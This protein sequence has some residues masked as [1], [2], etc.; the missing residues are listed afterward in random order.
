MVGH[1]LLRAEKT[2]RR[3]W[4]CVFWGG[5]G[6]PPRLPRHQ[7]ESRRAVGPGSVGGVFLV[8]VRMFFP[9]T[10]SKEIGSIF[11]TICSKWPLAGIIAPPFVSPVL[12]SMSP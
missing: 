8:S 12:F 4:L 1:H 9:K 7:Q 6:V 3:L 10:R 5:C 11:N 2:E